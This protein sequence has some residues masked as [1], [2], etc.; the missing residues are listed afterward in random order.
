MPL[1]LSTQEHLVKKLHT[2]AAAALLALS[3]AAFAQTTIITAA[4]AQ[5]VIVLPTKVIETTEVIPETLP[6]T[7]QSEYDARKEAV[8][9]YAQWKIECRGDAACLNQARADYNA[10]MAKLHMRATTGALRSQ[11]RG[12]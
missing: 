4:P 1:G 11:R 9:A 2:L 3:G 10:A 12:G 7:P 6:T 5:E 8:N